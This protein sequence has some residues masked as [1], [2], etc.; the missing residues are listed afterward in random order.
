VSFAVILQLIVT[1]LGLS[2][3]EIVSSLDN[4]IVNADV[5][6]T[7]SPWGRRWF[8]LWGILLAVFVVRG[9]LPWLIVWAVSPELGPWDALTA[10]LSGDP[11]A[12]SMIE[13]SAPILLNGGGVFLLFLFCH[14][15]FLQQKEFGLRPERFLEQQGVWFYAVVS[16]LLALIVWYGMHRDLH[17]GFAAVVG[18]TAFFI[19]Q[20]FKENAERV[21]QDLAEGGRGLSE[22][23][24]ILYLEVLDA[25]FSIDGVIG[26]FAFT[27]S[28]P[29]ILLGNGLGAVVLR[30]LT[31][32]HVKILRRYC[33]LKNGAMYS[34]GVLGAVM[35]LEAMGRHVPA[36]FP[37]LATFFII[38]YFG[39]RS[40]R[41]AKTREALEPG[42]P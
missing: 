25:S 26:A 33:L 9:A 13:G 14:W 4:A 11:A 15:I 2:L 40:F 32:R 39:W 17:V 3:F 16:A 23:S 35:V 21:E 27:V 37:P 29:L 12:R 34:V 10:T 5:L 22:L 31:V 7:M 24:K 19:T 38:G 6:D 28:V 30:T 18:S 42:R 41:L 36:W 1:V 20:G 8:L